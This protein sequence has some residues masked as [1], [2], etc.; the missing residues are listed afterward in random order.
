M[1]CVWRTWDLCG[2]YEAHWS[3]DTLCASRSVASKTETHG[4]ETMYIKC[5]SYFC[6]TSPAR[7]F[8]KCRRK[9]VQSSS[10]ETPRVSIA[11]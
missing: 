5:V 2:R 1:V 8:C 10:E 4:T 7:T 6:L 3:G 9:T 11:V